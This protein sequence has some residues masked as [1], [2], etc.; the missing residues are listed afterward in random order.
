MP[1]DWKAGIHHQGNLSCFDFVFVVTGALF[2]AWEGG[3]SEYDPKFHFN[4]PS[5]VI[6]L[7]KGYMRDSTEANG[8]V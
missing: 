4:S 1:D 7:L 5:S 2:V 8:V 3:K 6:K